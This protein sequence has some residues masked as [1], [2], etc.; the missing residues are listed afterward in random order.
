VAALVEMKRRLK[1]RREEVR[2]LVKWLMVDYWILAYVNLW[3]DSWCHLWSLY[4][5]GAAFGFLYIM[6]S[7]Q[8]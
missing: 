7:A 4:R 6:A 8:Y 1:I 3:F 2:N 5:G